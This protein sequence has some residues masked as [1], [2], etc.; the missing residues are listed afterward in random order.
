MKNNEISTSIKQFMKFLTV[1]VVFDFKIFSDVVDVYYVNWMSKDDK[2]YSLLV[3]ANDT[4]VFLKDTFFL[5]GF[6]ESTVFDRLY[7]NLRVFDS[8]DK[9]MYGKWDLMYAK[10]LNTAVSKYLQS[11]TIPCVVNEFYEVCSYKVYTR[12]VLSI[13]FSYLK[14]G[15]YA[16]NVFIP[17]D[18]KTILIGDSYFREFIHDL[19]LEKYVIWR[20]NYDDNSGSL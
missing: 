20:T 3:I 12:P 9:W 19:G 7:S 14:N 4:Q 11:F 10:N 8:K 17:F 16:G 2:F 15:V 5:G 18:R 13:S 1:S 6:S